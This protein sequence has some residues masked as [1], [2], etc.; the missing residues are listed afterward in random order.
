MEKI[1]E[2]HLEDF[3]TLK[4]FNQ[5]AQTSIKKINSE[6]INPLI[7]WVSS[8]LRH[9]R[10]SCIYLRT[11]NFS[12]WNSG[13]KQIPVHWFV[14]PVAFFSLFTYGNIH[15]LLP[16]WTLWAVGQKKHT[17]WLSITDTQL[18]P[19]AFIRVLVTATDVHQ[20]WYCEKLEA[21][22]A[23]KETVSYDL[24]L[25]SRVS[26]WA[27]NL[28]NT[29]HSSPLPSALFVS[30]PSLTLLVGFPTT[31]NISYCSWRTSSSSCSFHLLFLQWGKARTVSPPACFTRSGSCITKLVRM[32]KPM[33]FYWRTFMK[34]KN[35][36]QKSLVDS[37]SVW[38]IWKCLEFQELKSAC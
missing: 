33:A 15:F 20:I 4:L 27:K 7:L 30:Y 34:L 32:N 38:Y 14:V 35:F 13:N 25:V 18:W 5:Y 10:H 19:A 37:I 21:M 17:D 8:V 9:K 16:P 22:N 2:T 28:P 26:K 1:T 24:T 36:N 3:N 11:E 12:K 6:H 31:V 23:F 29:A